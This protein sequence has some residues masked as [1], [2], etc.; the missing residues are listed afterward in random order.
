[1]VI[2]EASWAG[3][4]VATQPCD[5]LHKWDSPSSVK[6]LV[7]LQLPVCTGIQRNLHQPKWVPCF[8]SFHGESAKTWGPLW[9]GS[10]A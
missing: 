5:L 4:L 1:M 7:S 2:A 10:G 3:F 6:I 8:Q 9:E